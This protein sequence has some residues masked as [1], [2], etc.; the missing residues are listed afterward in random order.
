MKYIFLN[1]KRFDVP[2]ALGGVNG[3]CDIENWGGYIINSIKEPVKK[4]ANAE[5]AVF[6]PEAHL[7]SAKSALSGND[8]INLGCQSVHF[9][10][11]SVNGNF[12]AYTTSRPAAAAAALGC[13]WAI[14]GHCEERNKLKEILKEGG[15]TDM[16]AVNS[17]LGKKI[18]CAV[19]SG[20]KVLYCIGETQEEQPIKTDVLKAQLQ[21]IKEYEDIVIGYEP[22]WAIG[23]G[24]T[25][26]DREYISEISEY[27]KS[28]V[29]RPVVYGG[30]LKTDN[31]GMLKSIGAID[32]GL[33]A[34]T[35]FAGDIGFYPGEYLEI[36]A[37]YL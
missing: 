23:P 10:N 3:I 14:I 31:A 35:R 9:N 6:L 24:K 29:N 26:P 16:S 7:L 20:L 8:K 11:I 30:G 36:V 21:V 17:I 28:V 15:C 2:K 13:K 27:V 33:I 34:L 25:P 19:E 37:K 12:G 5:F 18:K 22:V 4:Y 32:G 1:L